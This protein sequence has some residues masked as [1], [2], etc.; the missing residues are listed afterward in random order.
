MVLTFASA[1]AFAFA[2]AVHAPLRRTCRTR[3]HSHPRASQE[4]VGP[5]GTPPAPAARAAPSA[6]EAAGR[7]R[8]P[9]PRRATLPPPPPPP[10][11][12]TPTPT[13]TPQQLA[14]AFWLF[15]AVLDEMPSNFAG[16]GFPGM[17]IRGSNPGL[18]E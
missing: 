3:T 16:E 12:P 15:E 17:P 13:P 11:P 10:P 2:S 4:R 6:L 9:W 7:A 18:V 5:A 1:V 14:T 8:A